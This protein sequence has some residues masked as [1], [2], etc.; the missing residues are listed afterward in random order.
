[1]RGWSKARVAT[2]SNSVSVV[3][4][5][6]KEASSDESA[7][8]PWLLDLR[9]ALRSQKPTRLNGPRDSLTGRFM[10]H[11]H[12]YDMSV[13]AGHADAMGHWLTEEAQFSPEVATWRPTLRTGEWVAFMSTSR[14]HGAAGLVGFTLTIGLQPLLYALPDQSSPP[15][16]KYQCAFEFSGAIYSDLSFDLPCRTRPEL[17]L[18]G[19]L[20]AFDYVQP[21]AATNAPTGMLGM[22]LFG[23]REQDAQR[24][25]LGFSMDVELHNSADS[26]EGPAAAPPPWCTTAVHSLRLSGLPSVAGCP[27]DLFPDPL[28][29]KDERRM[30]TNL[31]AGGYWRPNPHFASKPPLLRD[32]SWLGAAMAWRAGAGAGGMRSEAGSRGFYAVGGELSALRTKLQIM[33]LQLKRRLEEQERADAKAQAKARKA[34]K[35]HVK[36]Q[37]PSVLPAGPT[38]ISRRGQQ[39]T[40]MSSSRAPMRSAARH[41]EKTHPVGET[42]DKV[43]V[44]AAAAA[45][46]TLAKRSVQGQWLEVGKALPSAHRLPAP[47]HHR[48]EQGPHPFPP[49]HRL[50]AVPSS[51]LPSSTPDDLPHPP[52][53]AS[54]F[55]PRAPS[56]AATPA[57]S[58]RLTTAPDPAV[59]RGTPQ[60]RQADHRADNRAVPSSES[61][62]SRYERLRRDR[63]RLSRD[64]KTPRRYHLNQNA[65]LDQQTPR[66]LKLQ[67]LALPHKA[68]PDGVAVVGTP[69]R[70][71]QRV[72]HVVVRGLDTSVDLPFLLSSQTLQAHD[73]HQHFLK[74]SAHASEKVPSREPSRELLD[75]LGA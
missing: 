15:P 5:A 52:P 20:K 8:A 30:L 6:I 12:A 59:M 71:P 37:E 26:R 14:E 17:R 9:D 2:A 35:V 42:P 70:R 43:V 29:R 45:S 4:D 39:Q 13:T 1:M 66:P 56:T 33:E 53:P 38:P 63:K 19:S 72:G 54:P 48:L 27:L 11:E 55:H 60:P 16:S 32:T 25:G 74:A 61:A 57:L 22:A 46:A 41:T 49:S 62:S 21:H 40:G 50:R 10:Q 58:S 67:Q 69:S 34:S 68:D 51:G 7:V 36:S 65:S 18:R 3:A 73:E 23:S 64:N 24:M 28:V 44:A 31:W 75:L 47:S